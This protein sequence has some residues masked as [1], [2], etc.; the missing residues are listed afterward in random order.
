[1]LPMSIIAAVAPID[2]EADCAAVNG[3]ERADLIKFQ[4]TIDAK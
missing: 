1:M 4:V 3:V 2:R